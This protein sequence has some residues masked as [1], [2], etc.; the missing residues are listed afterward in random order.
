MDKRSILILSTIKTEYLS[1]QAE[2]YGIPKS[3]LIQN[4][5]LL[6]E[7]ILRTIKID[8]IYIFNNGL[9]SLDNNDFK[10][11]FIANPSKIKSE[12]WKKLFIEATIINC[13]E[14]KFKS[15][16][17]YEILKIIANEDI[18]VYEE[19]IVPELYFSSISFSNLTLLT[20]KGFVINENIP[21][22]SSYLSD[23]FFVHENMPPKEEKLVRDNIHEPSSNHLYFKD[24]E[25]TC[26]F[27][28][29]TYRLGGQGNIGPKIAAKLLFPN[30]EVRAGR[31]RMEISGDE[32]SAEEDLSALQSAFNR[33]VDDIKEQE[34]EIKPKVLLSEYLKQKIKFSRA[35][36]KY[37]IRS[38]EIK[39]GEWKIELP[40]WFD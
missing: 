29:K 5:L 20:S 21:D 36:Q 6:D 7:N 3:K 23:G 12:K 4:I 11:Y 27:E 19:L 33:M 16:R 37:L 10:N 26:E 18:I 28:S 39:P 14:K 25:W 15:E 24:G 9:V 1:S 22:K 2:G 32:I 13:Y 8:Q 30:K 40:E 35:G 38:K 34:V 17:C 31:L